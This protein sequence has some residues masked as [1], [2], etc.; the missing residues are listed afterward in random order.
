[1]QGPMRKVVYVTLFEG[2]AIA[3]C[4]VSLALFSSHDAGHASVAAVG[5]SMIAVLWNL[6]YNTVFEAWEARQTVRGRSVARRIAHAL[7]F[8]G[9][10]LIMLVPFFAWWMDM[11]LWHA[12]V[13]DFGLVLFFLVYAFVFSW[14]F[15]HVF[16]LP[17]S[18][19]A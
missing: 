5:G 18:A 15:D 3:V 16:G 10:M 17:A 4:T 13:L 11:S 14:A 12:F 19:A 6:A 8:E 2:I 9:G 1:M 7:G